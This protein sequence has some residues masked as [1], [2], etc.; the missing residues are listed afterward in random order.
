M[1]CCKA[2]SFHIVYSDFLG[3]CVF[4]FVFIKTLHIL[5]LRYAA[6]LNLL[7]VLGM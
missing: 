7:V 5:E 1:F 3:V 2:N 4:I 6:L